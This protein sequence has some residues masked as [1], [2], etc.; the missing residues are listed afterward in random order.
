MTTS[1][2]PVP[3]LQERRRFC[4]ETS[5]FSGSQAEGA[6]N[7]AGGGLLFAAGDFSFG[8]DFSAATTE[9]AT[10]ADEGVCEADLE[11]TQWGVAFT[12]AG[13]GAHYY[14]GE[15]ETGADTSEITNI[16]VVYLFELADATVGP[17]FRTTTVQAVDG[18]ETTDT[19]ALFGMSMEF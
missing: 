17:E 4:R 6:G 7:A 18:S 1:S 14:F 5:I 2:W 11:T 9:C 8:L 19:F 16:D 10:A 3:L 13:L 15:A 12:L